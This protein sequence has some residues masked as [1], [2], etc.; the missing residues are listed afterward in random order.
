[1]SWGSERA[2]KGVMERSFA[3]EVEGRRIP[4]AFWRPEGSGDVPGLVML[5]HGGTADKRAP[6]LLAVARWLVRDHGL[7]AFAI[8]GPGHGERIPA[9]AQV[10]FK[11][12]WG[13]P[14]ATDA[15]IADWRGALDFVRDTVGN[16][17]LGYWG[18]SMGTMMGLPLVAALDDIRVALLGLMGIW[19]PTGDRLDADAPRVSLPGAVPRSM[20]R[21]DRAAGRRTRAFRAHRKRDQKTLH[22]NPGRHVEVPPDEMRNSAAFLA[23]PPR[24]PAA[25]VTPKAAQRV[26]G[27][28]RE[29]GG[30][31]KVPTRG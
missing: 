16:V 24:P 29:A 5:G 22:G 11:D 9:G 19:G 7:A 8:D 25:A 20:G 26:G 10:D 14:D 31:R 23:Q 13:A 21:R 18:L 12:A 28:T 1:M 4:G 15:V 27:G 6:Y 30:P 17:P 2:S 3:V